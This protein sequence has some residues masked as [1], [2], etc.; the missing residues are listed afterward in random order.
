M[1]LE[2][3]HK[4]S[5]R[6]E[7]KGSCPIFQKSRTFL[8][9]EVVRRL[10]EHFTVTCSALFTKSLSEIFS[11][12]ILFRFFSQ[13]MAFPVSA[14][15][16]LQA[17]FP[18]V[19]SPPDFLRELSLSPLSR[20]ASSCLMYT[21]S[22]LWNYN[23]KR[24]TQKRLPNSGRAFRSVNVQSWNEKAANIFDRL[25]CGVLSVCEQFL[26]NI[27]KACRTL[28][29]TICRKKKRSRHLTKSIHLCSFY[30]FC[31]ACGSFY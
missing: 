14:F 24:Q 10:C 6:R 22:R 20:E 15:P 16:S 28:S 23:K 11:S 18:Q 12:A 29:E 9:A 25:S 5:D 31:E 8:C 2:I 4:G 26:Q 19:H 21:N 30:W 17:H 27:K 1:I 7:R 13:H 3:S